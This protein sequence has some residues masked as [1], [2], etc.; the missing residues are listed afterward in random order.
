[1]GDDVAQ[2]LGGGAKDLG[3]KRFLVKTGKYREGDEKKADGLEGTFDDFA[4]LVE[5]IL[6]G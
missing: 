5:W 4:A 6:E 2:D 1:M 3:L